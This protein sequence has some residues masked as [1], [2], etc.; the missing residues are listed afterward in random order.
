MPR[1]AKRQINL[2][3]YDR[4]FSP[5]FLAIKELGGSA[6]IAEINA[7]A[8][9]I[10]GITDEQAE[11]PHEGQGADTEIEY[12]LHWAR[13]YLKRYGLLENSKGG[14]WALTELGRQTSKID[15]GEIKRVVKRQFNEEHKKKRV[16]INDV[17]ET[18]E[19]G[20]SHENWHAVLLDVLLHISPSSFERLVQRLL[21][22]SGFIQVDVT[23]RTGDGGIDGKG[24]LRMGGLLSFPIIFQCKR[25]K[26]PVGAK[27]IRDFR[28]AMV[29]RADK[30]LFVT[31]GS[32][33]LDAIKEATREGAPPIDTV[34][35]DQLAD[36]LKELGLGIQ[37]ELR[38]VVEIDREWFEGL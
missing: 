35:G 10:A 20:E 7:R 31:T 34:D 24:I 29:G 25:W 14:V 15:P 17:A 3:T 1:K 33:T 37:V 5:V 12:R 18:S 38:E 32:F 8:F 13:S 23:G 4:L 26:G 22:E 27:E 16:G 21:R 11:I 36:K 28:G 9:A 30:G 19:N 2:P 6:T